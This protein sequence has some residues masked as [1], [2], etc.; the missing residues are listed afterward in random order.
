LGLC[1]SAR[2]DL[3]G[4]WSL[5]PADISGTTAYDRSGQVPPNDGI[6]QRGPT[7]VPGII[8][9]ALS[10]DG[11][12]DF[13]EIPHS[14]SLNVNDPLSVGTWAQVTESGAW[15]RTLVAKYGF[16]GITPS[17]GLG[18]LNTRRLGF[19]VRDS[20]NNRS[21]VQ[22]PVDDLG[23]DGQWHHFL[24]VRGGGKVQFYVDGDLV[25]ETT[26]IS[27]DI[28]NT[29]QVTVARHHSDNAAN[30][31][32]G[33]FDDVA[34]WNEGLTPGQAYTLGRLTAP[35]NTVTPYSNAVLES[36]PV[37]YWRLEETLPVA[38]VADWSGNNHTGTYHGG[39]KGTA[40]PVPYDPLNTGVTLNG[41]GDHISIDSS[42]PAGIFDDG[43]YSV[44]LWFNADTRHQGDLAALTTGAGHAVL[45]E[46]ESDG[47]IRFLHRW[48]SGAGGGTNLY[49]STL[50]ATDQWH[51]LVAVKDGADMRLYVDGWL[52]P[53]TA[54]DASIITA[55]LDF[56]IGQLTPTSGER[57][58]D[59]VID[60][61]AL[62]D[63]ALSY[64]E[65]YYHF[66]G[67]VP[68][69]TGLALF[70]LGALCLGA[71]GLVARRRRAR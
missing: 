24:G 64:Q 16:S 35:A 5:D 65:I 28:T 18:W 13:I 66:T 15:F 8:G 57:F 47:R 2:G 19:Y 69:P 36:D 3:V 12:D 10:L 34:I 21:W 51:H 71:L 43:S 11:T 31:I 25:A 37:A 40:H 59:G 63:R 39:T 48:P 30:H 61:I 68:E 26:D 50:Y 56:T 38:K 62:Y 32:Q 58:F 49:S 23:L 45:L 14:A 20:S 55:D 54:S 46:L 44:E 53:V 17:W 60:E 6:L 9:G 41:S 27:G 1:A 42:L 22:S 67:V 7:Q 29:R 4:Y 33:V 70:G 52:D